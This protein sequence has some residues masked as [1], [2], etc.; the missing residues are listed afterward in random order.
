MSGVAA[1]GTHSL[2]ILQNIYHG[3]ME[4]SINHTDHAESVKNP[5]LSNADGRTTGV[6]HTK[7]TWVNG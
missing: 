7:I 5:L 2:C 3:H 1:T 4:C 6:G